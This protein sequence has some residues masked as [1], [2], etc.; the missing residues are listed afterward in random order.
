[1]PS[2]QT[3]EQALFPEDLHFNSST[4]VSRNHHYPAGSA[5]PL[6]PNLSPTLGMVEMTLA[7]ERYYPVPY[8]ADPVANFSAW[9][10]TTQIFQANFYRSQIAYY[11]RGSGFPER[12]LGSIYWQLE[13]IWQAPTWSSVEYDGRWKMLHYLAKDIFQ[14]VII[15]SYWNYTSGDL[16]AYVTSDLWTPATGLATFTWYVNNGGVKILYS[17]QSTKALFLRQR[18]KNQY[19]LLPSFFSNVKPVFRLYL[20]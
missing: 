18:K 15:A 2:L 12:Q 4:I 14:P 19:S 17:F 8:F 7:A 10:H 16:T 1:M 13:D 6:S 5:N 20:F 9:C 11:R 3:W